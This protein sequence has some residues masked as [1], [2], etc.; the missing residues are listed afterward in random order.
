MYFGFIINSL[1]LFTET[2]GLNNGGCDRVCKD[3][4]TGVQCSCPEGYE[5]QADGRTCRGKDLKWYGKEW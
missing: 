5:L 4:P 2:C 3:T 1:L